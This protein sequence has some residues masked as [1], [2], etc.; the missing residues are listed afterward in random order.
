[1]FSKRI[2]V[3]D[4][5]KYDKISNSFEEIAKFVTIKQVSRRCSGINEVQDEDDFFVCNEI[6]LHC[7]GMDNLS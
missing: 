5:W 6:V 7:L 1:M 2:V 3:Q 4:K